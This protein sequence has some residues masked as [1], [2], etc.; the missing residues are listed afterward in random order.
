MAID[1]SIRGQLAYGKQQ[2][3]SA[4]IEEPRFEAELLLGD[5]LDCQNYQLHLHPDRQLEES[6]VTAYQVLIS[7]R[8]RHEPYAYIN[9]HREFYSLDFLVA[10]G[11]LIP[12]PETELLV[13]LTLDLAQKQA[14]HLIADVGTGSGAIACSV[15]HELAGIKVL[16][17][18]ISPDA[19]AIAAQ[20]IRRLGLEE[21]V[22]PLSSDLLQAAP[23]GLDLILSNP[24][25]IPSGDIPGLMPEVQKEPLLALDGG[26]DGLDPY[27][28]LAPQA[29]EKLNNNGW[30]MVEHGFDQ[31][32]AV[33][34]IFAANGFKNIKSY[35]DFSA[36]ER[37]T[38]A[39]K[40]E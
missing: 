4:A 40:T 28:L 1:R 3:Q 27:R 31:A 33:R 19:L 39:Q 14:L 12:R 25:Y 36:I 37:V 10:P 20:N 21:R 22:N 32:P 13:D 11:V 6:Q 35:K 15:A 16:A 9:G 8:C 29:Y 26:K 2:L 30:L 24:P 18:D 7:R 34:Q 38:V 5:I 23:D 17:L